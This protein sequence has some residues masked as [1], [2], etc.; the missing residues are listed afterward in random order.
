MEYHSA[1]KNQDIMKFADQR[2]ELE[3]IIPKGH[4][5]DVLTY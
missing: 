2:M 1:I 4:A 3:D 5:W